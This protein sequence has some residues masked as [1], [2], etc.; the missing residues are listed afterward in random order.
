MRESIQQV[1]WWN[2][3]AKEQVKN[4]NWLSVHLWT[5][6]AN[7]GIFFLKESKKLGYIGWDSR[8]NK[9]F[10]EA[11]LSS[12]GQGSIL[13][14]RRCCC[15]HFRQLCSIVPPTILNKN[16][17]H[18]LWFSTFQKVMKIREK[19]KRWNELK[20][21]SWTPWCVCPLFQ[22]SS[23]LVATKACDAILWSD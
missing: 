17:R 9:H 15:I 14:Q 11:Y 6:D 18:H 12:T 1:C 8:T 7:L 22:R 16:P 19:L 2:W 23:T 13:T 21:N 3:N 20:G 10:L 4:A 5:F